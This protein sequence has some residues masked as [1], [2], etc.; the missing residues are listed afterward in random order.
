MQFKAIPHLRSQSLQ[1]YMAH[2]ECLFEHYLYEAR[3]VA[4]RGL[5]VL[6]R[7][8]EF[9]LIQCDS[10]KTSEEEMPPSDK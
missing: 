5:D 6:Y 8:D 10:D 7:S 9:L 2:Q 1:P 4:H 3:T